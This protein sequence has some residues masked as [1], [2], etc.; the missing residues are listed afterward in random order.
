MGAGGGRGG[1]GLQRGEARGGVESK[2]GGVEPQSARD[3]R[4]KDETTCGNER[5]MSVRKML[6][7]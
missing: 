5:R 1:P 4:R 3:G 6:A 2:E 7:L